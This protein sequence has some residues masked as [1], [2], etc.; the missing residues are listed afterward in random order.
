MCAD[1]Y[2]D[3]RLNSY[4]T[5][6]VVIKLN[7]SWRIALAAAFIHGL[8]FL[9][10]SL[11][12]LCNM[13]QLYA[14]PSIKKSITVGLGLFQAL[15]GFESMRLVVQGKDVLLT[16]GDVE[17]VRVWLSV[18]GLLLIAVLLVW[19]VKA[20]MLLG[21]IVI[22]LIG[23]MSGLEQPPT[24]I[25]QWPSINLYSP[26]FTGYWQHLGQTAPVT[27][28]FLFVSIFD[29]AGVQLM[30]AGQA[31]LL[32]E[33][34]HLSHKESTAAFVAAA[35]ATCLGAVLGTS[36][37]IIHTGQ[38]TIHSRVSQP[39]LALYLSHPMLAVVLPLFVC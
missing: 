23:W 9:L 7:L 24:A 34:G 35:L 12:G 5:Y 22:T 36:P 6:G 8:L 33:N 27:L 39:L 4:F 11:V 3:C 30:A 19:R 20:A 18:S 1:C 29:T 38:S 13:L 16:L 31:D 21:M 26:D 32:D 17:D 25:L 15:I 10:L 14:P 2:V 28:M 37:I